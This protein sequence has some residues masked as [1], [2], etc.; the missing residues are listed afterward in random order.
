MSTAVSRLPRSPGDMPRARVWAHALSTVATEEQWK[1][2]HVYVKQNLS[3]PVY[4]KI[5]AECEWHDVAAS[6]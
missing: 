4:N 3:E 2:W 1:Q 5:K 6:A